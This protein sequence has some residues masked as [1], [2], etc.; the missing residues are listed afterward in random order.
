VEPTGTSRSW[1]A[2]RG[3]G[4]PLDGRACGAPARAL[5]DDDFSSGARGPRVVPPRGRCAPP[6]KSSSRA[7]GVWQS[8]G[9]QNV[10]GGSSG[11]RA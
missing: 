11:R 1:G 8:R 3:A 2:A 6:P 5:L 9:L 10:Y 7:R 4:A